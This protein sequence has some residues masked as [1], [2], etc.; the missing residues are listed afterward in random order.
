MKAYSN[1]KKTLW[2]GNVLGISLLFSGCALNKDYIAASNVS[3][4]G[5][6]HLEE[7]ERVVVHVEVNDARTIRDRVSVKKNGYGMEMAPIIATND[8]A[9][10]LKT[11]LETELTDRGFH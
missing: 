8:V 2:A 4:T 10:L 5:V 11:A 3:Q 1:I 6:A 7:A 9:A